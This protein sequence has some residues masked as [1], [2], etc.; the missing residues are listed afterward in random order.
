MHCKSACYVDDK[1]YLS[2]P[3]SDI[4]TA[5][6]NLNEDSRN[7]CGWCCRNSL[8][9]NS[10]KTKVLFIGSPQV[11]CQLPSVPVMMFGKEISRYRRQRPWPLPWSVTYNVHVT[12]TVANCR[13][14]LVQINRMKHLLD[15]KTT[16]LLKN[17]FIF[18]NLFYCLTVW[19]NTSKSNI[20]KL[21]LVKNFAAHIVLGLWKYDHISEIIRSLNWLCVRDRHHVNDAV[22]SFKCIH[23]FILGHLFDKFVFHSQIATKIT[24]QSNDL[25]IPRCWLVTEQQ[26]FAYCGA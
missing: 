24:R 7:I 6:D 14:K 9:I 16:L 17:S 22:M 19:S 12:K 8:L 3:S 25:N 23:D 20:R 21:Q 2:F 1:L 13:H 11:L 26:S 18:S 4:T 10:D 15:K 5:I